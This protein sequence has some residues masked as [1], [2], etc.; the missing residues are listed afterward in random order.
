LEIAE[1][2]MQEF[3]VENKINPENQII[4]EPK[5]KQKPKKP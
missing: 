4:S 2:V 1:K 3:F 5:C